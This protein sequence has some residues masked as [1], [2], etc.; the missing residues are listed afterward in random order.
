MCHCLYSNCHL[1]FTHWRRMTCKEHLWNCTVS[2]YIQTLTEKEWDVEVSSLYESESLQ[3]TEIMS[4]W[5]RSLPSTETFHRS[6]SVVQTVFPANDGSRHGPVI[7]CVIASIDFDLLRSDPLLWLDNGQA[8][9]AEF[10]FIFYHRTFSW[11]CSGELD[12][13]M[14]WK[15]CKG[16]KLF[17]WC[18]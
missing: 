6:K 17:W 13:R 18:N 3:T 15:V 1:C 10:I 5:P 11:M 4:K 8:P 12:P 2:Q 9:D 14:E 16:A 7:W